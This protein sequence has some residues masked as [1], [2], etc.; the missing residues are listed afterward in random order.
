M[1]AAGALSELL[2]TR[3]LSVSCALRPEGTVECWGSDVSSPGP[4]GMFEAI[5]VGRGYRCGLR[6]SGKVD[7]WGESNLYGEMDPPEGVF[8]AV[9]AAL[10]RTCGVRP[11]G[12][13]QCWG[14]DQELPSG[15]KPPALDVTF[16]GGDFEAV[17]VGRAH[18]CGLRSDREVACWGANWFGQAEAPPGPFVAVDAGVSH[19]CGLRPDGS[20]DCWGEDSL[21]AAELITVGFRFGGD[22]GAYVAN[23]RRPEE[24][25]LYPYA[26]AFMDLEGA[27]PEPELRAEMV[28][29]AARWEPPK[30][31]FVAMN[32]TGFVG[33]S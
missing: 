25:V 13:V 9:S 11:E 5:S 12:S 20:I 14:G 28:R 7:C 15:V 33:G 24:W 1:D 23:S 27:V 16:P 19:S 18:V 31:P 6:L 22:E 26:V 2:S 30:G 21:D 3:S 32:R 17:S 10:R 4:E 8:T 29:R